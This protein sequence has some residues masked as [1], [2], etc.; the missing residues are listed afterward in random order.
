[1][2]A[3]NGSPD[4]LDDEDL[5]PSTEEMV[6]ARQARAGVRPE[7]IHRRSGAARSVTIGVVAILL[8]IGSVVLVWLRN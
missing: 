1:M 6:A 3:Q 7:R 5:R 2:A 8:A 4:D